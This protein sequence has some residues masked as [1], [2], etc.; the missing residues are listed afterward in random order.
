MADTWPSSWYLSDPISTSSPDLSTVIVTGQHG[1]VVGALAS[2][3]NI[4]HPPYEFIHLDANHTIG[5]TVTI[6]GHESDPPQPPGGVWGTVN[7]DGIPGYNQLYIGDSVSGSIDL[8]DGYNVIS[9]GTQITLNVGEEWVATWRY[10]GYAPLCW[11]LCVYR[12][13]GM[14]FSASGPGRFPSV[15]HVPRDC[16]LSSSILIED[17]VLIPRRKY[18]LIPND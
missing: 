18:E 9:N 3:G 8:T 16:D 2:L 6:S 14:Q 13:K 11:R 12:R 17:G 10:S 15:I 1:Y 7:G 5:V 4:T